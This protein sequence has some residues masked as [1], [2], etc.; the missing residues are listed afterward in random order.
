[1]RFTFESVRELTERDRKYLGAASL[2]HR[3]KI[4]RVVRE[5]GEAPTTLAVTKSAPAA[6]TVPISP[7]RRA[8]AALCDVLWGKTALSPSHDPRCGRLC[9]LSALLH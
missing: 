5:L 3:R 6:T 2:G 9:R 8:S 4:M 1:M 7:R